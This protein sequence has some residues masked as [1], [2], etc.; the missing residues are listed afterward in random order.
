VQKLK[1]AKVY[2]GKGATKTTRQTHKTS[3]GEKSAEKA[4]ETDVAQPVEECRK[5]RGGNRV[6]RH[7]KWATHA[8]EHK[9]SAERGSKKKHK[10]EK[11]GGCEQG[12]VYSRKR[13]LKGKKCQLQRG[14]GKIPGQK[15]GEEGPETN[16][17]VLEKNKSAKTA[18]GT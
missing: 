18:R 7:E 10:W 9:R 12:T 13:K 1:V 5:S 16:R 4:Q 17:I 2:K 14:E 3:S 6:R 15:R 11:E 8:Q